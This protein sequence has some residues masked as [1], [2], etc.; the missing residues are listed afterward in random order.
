MGKPPPRVHV[1]KLVTLPPS[2]V[3]FE[4]NRTG[5]ITEDGILQYQRNYNPALLGSGTLYGSGFSYSTFPGDGRPDP[6]AKFGDLPYPIRV[7]NTYSYLSIRMPRDKCIHYAFDAQGRFGNP[8]GRSLL[9]RAY[10][11]WVLKNALLRMLAIAMDRKGTPI[12]VV[13]T[14]SNQTVLKQDAASQLTN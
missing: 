6:F 11:F 10:N 13:Y 14:D 4:V 5:D 8:Y 12:L 2:T 9:R 7:G 3:L 1:E